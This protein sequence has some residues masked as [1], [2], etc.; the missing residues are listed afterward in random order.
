MKQWYLSATFG[1]SWL[2][3]PVSQDNCDSKYGHD[4]RNSYEGMPYL[5]FIVAINKKVPPWYAVPMGSVVDSD[6]AKI[7]IFLLT[8]FLR[9]FCYFSPKKWFHKPCERLFLFFFGVK[10]YKFLKISYLCSVFGTVPVCW[11]TAI[12]K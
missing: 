8:S 9:L 2:V 5:H 11:L 3:C 7:G 6:V 1:V 10:R 4:D 12:G